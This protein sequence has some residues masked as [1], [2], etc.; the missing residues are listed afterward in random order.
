VRLREV[1][2]KLPAMETLAHLATLAIT[3]LLLARFV[4]NVRVDSI[5]TAVVVAV[6][7]SVLNFFLGWLLR[8][9][10][11]VPALLTLGLLF[12]FVPFIVNT[13]L[14]WLTDKLIASFEIRT[15]GSLLLSST[16]ITIVN[17]LFYFSYAHSAWID[18]GHSAG[19]R[20]I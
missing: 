14:L 13:V 5:G 10:L 6:V 7:F 19:P 12:L 16:I 15:M 8:A 9:A 4:P 18:S 17:G 11:V 3:I 1:V 20:W 2:L